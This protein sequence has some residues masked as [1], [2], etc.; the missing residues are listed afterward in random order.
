M[1]Y[2]L[3]AKMNSRF[4]HGISLHGVQ[5]IAV[6]FVDD[7]FIFS[8]ADKENVDNIIDTLA[9]FSE[10]WALYINRKKSA[11]VDI[12]AQDVQGIQWEGTR[13]EKGTVFTHLGYPLGI[14]VSYK[15]K[16]QWVMSKIKCKTGMWHVSQWPLHARV[17]IVQAFLQPYVMYC[18]LLLD[19]KKCHIRGFEC[20]LK[21]FL[22]EKKHNRALVLS[23]WE[24]VCQPR[25]N[26][27]LGILNLHAHTIARWV[28]FIMRVTSA[29]RP[30]WLDVFWKTR[31][32]RG[33]F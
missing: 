26:G 28:A 19:W 7:T 22:W 15:D 25:A 5:Q 30:L 4:I 33:P 23:A 17:R 27:G 11:L 1:F 12:S 3:E 29:H 32:C 6:G 14:N 18:L 13:I 24:L 2:L 16:I 10:A 9:L 21:N 8:K 31:K 20:L